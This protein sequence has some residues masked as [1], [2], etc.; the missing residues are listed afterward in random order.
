MSVLNVANARHADIQYYYTSRL[1]GEPA[2]GV[3]DIH[4]HPVEP[5]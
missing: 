3:E 1:P 4:F 5:R 2:Q